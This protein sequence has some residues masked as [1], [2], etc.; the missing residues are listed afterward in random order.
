MNR[1]LV[2]HIDL[3]GHSVITLARHFN[4]TLKF[5]LI[6]ARDYGFEENEIEFEFLKKF[7]E[8]IIADLSIPQEK[9]QELRDAGVIVSH[10]DHHSKA[11]WLASDEGSSHDVN[12]CGTKI[13]WEDYI[14]PKIG[15]FPVIIN[16]FVELVDT[17]DL[18]KQESPLWERAKNLNNILTGLKDW[19][20]TDPIEAAL[21]FYELFEKK[22][23]TMSEWTET[24]KEIEIVESA[25]KREEE[26]YQRAMKKLQIR[27]DSKGKVFA[28]TS[29]PSKISIVCSRILEEQENLDYIVAFN[30]WGGLSGKLSFRSRNGFNCNDIGVANGHD[31]AAGGTIGIEESFVFLEKP[32]LAFA[33]NE[34]YDE[35]DPST[36]F[37][38][39]EL[40]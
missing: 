2:S 18:W 8:V 3:D 13:F 26:V 33:Y 20:A 40:L 31:A 35:E 17:Y 23:L 22:L 12:R 30:T 19:D 16:E 32:S 37:E 9:T 14:K 11:D 28:V 34:K 36:A 21:G 10:Y 15:R 4:E 29:M 24:R 38:E 7:K 27:I 1:I 39:V 5:D 6:W 25:A